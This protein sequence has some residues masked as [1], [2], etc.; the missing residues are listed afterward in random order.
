MKSFFISKEEAAVLLHLLKLDELPTSVLLGNLTE[1]STQRIIDSLVKKQLCISKDG[2]YYPDKG[3]VEFLLPLKEMKC[4][5]SVLTVTH[6]IT[7]FHGDLYFSGKG[8]TAI[9]EEKEEVQFCS[10]ASFEELKLFLPNTRD[11]QAEA[12]ATEFTFA[13]IHSDHMSCLNAAI[14]YSADEVRVMEINSVSKT[15][16]VNVISVDAFQK[17][18]EEELREVSKGCY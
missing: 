16:E 9:R 4:F 2:I 5:L 6:L 1:E 10:F 3:L 13:A 8:I 18:L 14:H 17:Q 12:K 7:R 11:Y 15:E